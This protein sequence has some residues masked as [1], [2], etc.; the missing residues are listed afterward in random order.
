MRT[1]S[2]NRK[3]VLLAFTLPEVMIAMSL[4]LMV[5]AGLLTTHLCGMRMFQVTQTKITASQDARRALSQ[6]TDEV[7]GAKWVEI[8]SV[9]SNKFTPVADDARQEG[10]AIQIY[11]SGTNSPYIRYYLNTSQQLRRTFTGA[12][13]SMLIASSIT[14]KV[15]FASEDIFGNVLSTNQNNRVIALNLSIYQLQYPIVKAGQRQHYDFYQLNTKITRRTL[16]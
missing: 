14:N 7:R 8:G 3:S 5:L 15:I 11:N 12:T 13:Q 16:E 4:V 6:I 2:F 10:N 9:V 1:N